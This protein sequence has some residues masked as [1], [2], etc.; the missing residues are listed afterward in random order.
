[1]QLNSFITMLFCRV[2]VHLCAIHLMCLKISLIKKHKKAFQ[3]RGV[4]GNTAQYSV[5]AVWRCKLSHHSMFP[6]SK[7]PFVGN[8]MK[9]IYLELLSNLFPKAFQRTAKAGGLEVSTISKVFF[10]FAFVA[11]PVFFWLACIC[12]SLC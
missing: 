3:Y 7:I 4:M 9:N 6:Y 12:F 11:A 10:S 8:Y 2:P 5:Y 1:M